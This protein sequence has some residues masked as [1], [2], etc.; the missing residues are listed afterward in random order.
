MKFLER[1]SIYKKLLNICRL[2]KIVIELLWGTIRHFIFFFSIN[3]PQSLSSA[4]CY[5]VSVVFVQFCLVIEGPINRPLKK[6]KKHSKMIL[7]L[8]WQEK[9]Y[10]QNFPEI[11]WPWQMFKCILNYKIIKDLVWEKIASQLGKTD[12][13]YGLHM[14]IQIYVGIEFMTD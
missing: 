8:I 3:L 9:S 7:K 10:S 11:A 1:F 13:I 14:W 6:K 12:S 5:S 4:V 2:Y